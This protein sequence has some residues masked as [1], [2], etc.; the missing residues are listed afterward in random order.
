MAGNHIHVDDTAG[1]VVEPAP[2]VGVVVRFNG[3]QQP[4]ILSVGEPQTLDFGSFPIEVEVVQ[5]I[6]SKPRPSRKPPYTWIIESDDGEQ[7][8]V[9]SIA[10]KQARRMFLRNNEGRK[11]LEIYPELD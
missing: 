9:R 2:T 7:Y 1:S 6:R 3:Q 10:E 11:I 5:I 8:K 4:A